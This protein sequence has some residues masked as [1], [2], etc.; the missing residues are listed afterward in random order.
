MENKTGDGDRAARFGD[1]VA[2]GAQILHGL[3]N[4]IFGD[5]DDVIHVGANVL[6]VDGADALSAKAIGDGAGDLFGRELDDLSRAQAGLGVGGE[7]RL[8][9]NNF[10]FR[11]GELDRGGHAADEASATNWGKDGLN[12]GKVF[13]DLEADGA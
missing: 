5:R 4:F 12:V 2:I 3:A 11:I 13:E 6:E 9:A 10:Y 8:D 7:L 1:R